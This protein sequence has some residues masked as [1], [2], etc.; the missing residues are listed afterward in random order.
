M[1]TPPF[2]HHKSIWEIPLLCMYTIVF[3]VC[4]CRRGGR[5][6]KEEE[7]G[8][9]HVDRSEDQSTDRMWWIDRCYLDAADATTATGAQHIT[10]GPFIP[11]KIWESSGF[12]FTCGAR[13]FALG[14]TSIFTSPHTYGHILRGL[15]YSCIFF[16][17]T[18]DGFFC[19]VLFFVAACISGAQQIQGEIIPNKCWQKKILPI[20][21]L[22]QF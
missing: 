15:M 18:G 6:G 21:E 22:K 8:Q 10:Q 4:P 9:P 2:L 12:F 13:A 1:L 3:E 7:G 17:M 20:L 14:D 5:Q 16:T 11:R 19:R